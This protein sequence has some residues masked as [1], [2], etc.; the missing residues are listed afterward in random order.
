MALASLLASGLAL[1]APSV[2]APR[3]SGARSRIRACAITEAEEQLG[4]ASAAVPEQ[5]VALAMR[6]RYPTLRDI[7][8]SIRARRTVEEAE[9]ALK[10]EEDFR[11]DPSL[12]AD[13]DFAALLGGERNAD[14]KERVLLW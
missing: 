11:V 13:I 6:E 9:L 8:A 7:S 2:H 5:W 14:S 12:F 10:V 4:G 3:R 1:R